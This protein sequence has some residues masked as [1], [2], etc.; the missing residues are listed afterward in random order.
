MEN[1]EEIEIVSQYGLV[2]FKL[3]TEYFYEC[4]DL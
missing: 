2:G 3:H 4:Y 1:Y